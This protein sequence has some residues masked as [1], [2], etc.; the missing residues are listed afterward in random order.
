M[1]YNLRNRSFLKEIDFTRG[2]FTFLLRL[3]SALEDREVRGHRNDAPRRQRDRPDL[4]EDLHPDALLVRSRCVR[5]GR[6]RHLPRPVGLADRP[7]GVDRRHG[8]G[9]GPHVRRHRVPREQPDR[10]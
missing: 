9:P 6:S 8:E 5:P 4:R 2:E 3:A 7:Q 1:A 10:R